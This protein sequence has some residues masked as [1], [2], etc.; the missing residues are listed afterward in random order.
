MPGIM[1]NNAL[2]ARSGQQRQFIIYCFIAPISTVM[3]Q[4]CQISLDYHGGKRVYPASQTVR[5]VVY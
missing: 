1:E 2:S 5:V 4:R 3:G